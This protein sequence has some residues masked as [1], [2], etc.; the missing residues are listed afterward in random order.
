MFLC[1]RGNYIW[2]YP[3]TRCLWKRKPFCS[4]LS[5]KLHYKN[6]LLDYLLKSEIFTAMA[7]MRTLICDVMACN[8]LALLLFV[9]F[10]PQSVGKS[11]LWKVINLSAVQPSP[12]STFEIHLRFIIYYRQNLFLC[13][14]FG[15]PWSGYRTYG[16]WIWMNAAVTV[17]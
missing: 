3:N 7:I 8:L 2:C 16:E 9:L 17:W 15:N 13:L 5:I 12:Y 1:I 14:K 6:K 10:C 11:F 4:R